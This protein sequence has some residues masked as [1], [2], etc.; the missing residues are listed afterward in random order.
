MKNLLTLPLICLSLI[1]SAQKISGFY[2][3]SLYNDST[4]MTQRY[5]LALNEYKGKI[6]GYSYVTFVKNDT[7]YYGI[8]KIKAEVVGDSLVV[9][10][11]KMIV[12]NFPQK[13]DKGVHRII[14]IPLKGQDSVVELTGNW[15]TTR[16]RNFY[17]IPGVIQ[18]ARSTD[19]VNSPLISHLKE[20]NIISSDNY[21]ST[22]TKVKVK[23]EKTKIKTETKTVEPKIAASEIKPV[24]PKAEVK[25]SY[26]QRAS[27]TLQTI[28]AHSDSLLLSFYDNGVIDGDSI[29]VY[30][31]N[32]PVILNARLASTAT[33]KSIY[34]GNMSEMNLLLVA[35]NLGTLPPNTGLL[36]IRDGEDVYQINFSADLQ[37]NAMITIRRKK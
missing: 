5:E 29:S 8:R 9:E 30:L 28:T 34:V 24:A 27:K 15:K 31:N 21:A 26:D 35:E 23:E 18:M 7:F 32:Q 12:N 37:T 2:S 6:Y 4:K 22:E 14:T 13:P 36:M 11:D 33:R 25:L 19:S 10:D 17:S 16:T 1:C 20:L 3:G